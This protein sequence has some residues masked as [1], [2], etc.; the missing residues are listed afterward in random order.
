MNYLCIIV[1]KFPG[2]LLQLSCTYSY[3]YY[4][5]IDATNDI[6]RQNTGLLTVCMYTFTYG[7]E[8]L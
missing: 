2:I 8:L 5:F 7:S 6:N 1:G 4:S 3:L